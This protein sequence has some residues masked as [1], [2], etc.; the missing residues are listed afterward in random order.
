[1][2]VEKASGSQGR[3]FDQSLSCREKKGLKRLD[4][5]EQSKKREGGVGLIIGGSIWYARKP[6]KRGW[7]IGR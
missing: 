1:M 4:C 5:W 7:W 6:G 2:K 3:A